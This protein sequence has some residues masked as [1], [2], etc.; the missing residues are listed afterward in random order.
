LPDD[1]VSKENAIILQYS[2]RVPLCIDPQNQANS[3]LK[4]MGID[5]HIDNKVLF[6]VMKATDEKLIFELEMAIK[7]GK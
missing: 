3:F 1:D 4:K 5:I 7:L 2:K 6:K